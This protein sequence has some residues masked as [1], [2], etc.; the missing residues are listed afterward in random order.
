LARTTT[1]AIMPVNSR[2]VT[3]G[4]CLCAPDCPDEEVPD[5]MPVAIISATMVPVVATTMI[6]AAVLVLIDILPI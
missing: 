5:S 2:E 4:I 3:R 6:P 1:S